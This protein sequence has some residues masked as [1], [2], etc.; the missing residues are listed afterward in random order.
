MWYEQ[1][2]THL[3]HIGYNKCNGDPNIYIW[4]T[5]DG[6]FILLGLY[7]DDLVIVSPNLAYLEQFKA[8]LVNE[9]IMTDSDDLSY[10]LDIQVMQNPF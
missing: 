10:C 9:S 3:L 8:K 1:F 7:V 2:I 5:K 6:I 4:R